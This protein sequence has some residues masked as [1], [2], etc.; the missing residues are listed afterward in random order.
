MH[1]M[2]ANEKRLLQIFLLLFF[3]YLTIFIL[4]KNL[5][6]DFL[7]NRIILSTLSQKAELSLKKSDLIDQ[8]QL[9]AIQPFNVIDTLS[10]LAES[11]LIVNKLEKEIEQNSNEYIS[12]SISASGNIKSILNWQKN[13]E[14]LQLLGCSKM[15]IMAEEDHLDFTAQLHIWQN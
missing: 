13:T 2:S 9:Q 11:G 3:L 12:Y 8:T 10:L 15:K 6:P 7:N 1:N 5:V 14:K 4:G